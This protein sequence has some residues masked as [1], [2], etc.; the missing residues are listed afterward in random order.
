MDH[1]YFCGSNHCRCLTRD[2]SVA[3]G[4]AVYTGGGGRH[5]RSVQF[6]CRVGGAW[7]PGGRSSFRCDSTSDEASPHVVLCRGL[8]SLTRELRAR[9]RRPRAACRRTKSDSR[10]YRRR[11]GTTALEFAKARIGYTGR[12]RDQPGGTVGVSREARLGQTLLHDLTTITVGVCGKRGLD[13][14]WPPARQPLAGGL[15]FYR[16]SGEA[17]TRAGE[18]SSE[19]LRLPGDDVEKRTSLADDGVPCR[20]GREHHGCCR[21]VQNPAFAT[22]FLAHHLAT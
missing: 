2:E 17:V 18:N 14:T 16:V 12:D 3:A 10:A 6:H 22:L 19:R 13:N 11:S 8:T 4:P 21:L 5:F 1:A 7:E 20:H 9:P 15:K